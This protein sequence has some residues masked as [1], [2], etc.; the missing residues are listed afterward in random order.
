[1]PS[2]LRM[3]SCLYYYLLFIIW[4]QY[5][6]SDVAPPL[7]IIHGY[8]LCGTVYGLYFK[9]VLQWT[10]NFKPV[11][12]G[13]WLPLR[14]HRLQII[15]IWDHHPSSH[16]QK[17]EIEIEMRRSRSISHAGASQFTTGSRLQNCRSIW[18]QQLSARWL[19]MSWGW[20]RA[21][22]FQHFD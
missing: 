3:L 15:L 9:P 11:K 19:L 8:V 16:S 17:M 22:I 1:M 18:H 12:A 14:L 20:I 7:R 4:L 5:P 21:V 13:R 6:I 10:S 2:R